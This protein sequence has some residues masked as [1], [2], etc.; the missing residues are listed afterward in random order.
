MRTLLL[1]LL[2]CFSAPALAAEPVAVWAYQPSP[3]FASGQGRGLSE[4]LVELLNEHP[5]NQDRFEFRLS[6]LPR[7]RLDAAG[8]GWRARRGLGRTGISEAERA[9]PAPGATRDRGLS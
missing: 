6:Q 1:W 4:A 9:R 5:S 8:A 7:K 2:I 3:P